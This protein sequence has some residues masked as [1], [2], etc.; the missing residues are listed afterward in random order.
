VRI[1]PPPGINREKMAKVHELKTH[2]I[3]FQAIE[4]G[5]KRFEYRVN[6]RGYE[7]GD[8]LCLKEYDPDKWEY[9]GGSQWVR[10]EYILH[11]GQYGIPDGYCIMSICKV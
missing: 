1:N 8:L 7:V 11:G 2:P 10:V 6:D 3:P 4:S 5:L 9:P